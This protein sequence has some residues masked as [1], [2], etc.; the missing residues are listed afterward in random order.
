MADIAWVPVQG[1]SNIDSIGYDVDKQ[2]C[3]VKYLSGG[4]YV[5]SNVPVEQYEELM[6]SSSKGRYVSIVLRRAHAVRKEESSK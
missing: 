5:Y 4:I 6:N 2:E 3:W 1:S